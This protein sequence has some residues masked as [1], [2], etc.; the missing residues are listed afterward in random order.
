MLVA[1]PRSEA[2]VLTQG[3]WGLSGAQAPVTAV[4]RARKAARRVARLVTTEGGLVCLAA[5]AAYLTAAI[6]L[7]FVYRSLPGDAVSRMANGFYVLY[8]RDPHLAAIGFVWTPLTSIAGMVPLLFKSLW[9]ALATHD[10]AGSLV[11][12]LCMTGV[13]HQLRSSLLEWGVRRGPRLILTCLFALNPMIIFF[14]ANGMSEAVYMFALTAATRYL[15]RWL[16]NGEVRSIAYS[17]VALGLGYLA[18]NETLAAALLAALMVAIVSFVRSSGDRRRRAMEALTDVAILIG[19][20]VTA[21]VGWASASLVIT[22]QAFQQYQGNAV[23]V[24][25][26]GFTPGTVATRL[27]H[28]AV[29]L[30]F[31]APALP[32]VAVLALAL[33]WRRR[34]LQALV[35]VAILG[36]GLA[37]ILLSYFHGLLFPWLRYYILV[38]PLGVLLAGY[39]LSPSSRPALERGHSGAD[40]APSRDSARSKRRTKVIGVIG[41]TASF[42]ALAPSLPTSAAAM[43]D[44][45]IGAGETIQNLG[46]I[47]HAHLTPQDRHA[48]GHSAFVESIGRYISKMHLPDG[49]IVVDNEVGCVPEIITNIADPK[50]FVI[51]NDRDFQRVLADPLTFHAHYLID[52]EG[53]RNPDLV[54]AAAILSGAAAGKAILVHKFPQGGLCPE[55]RLYR[56]VGHPG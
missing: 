44:P 18:R 41:A 20:F 55:L 25:A 33:A 17:A 51:P 8:S 45:T 43:L 7:D 16:R 14:A 29:A 53:T 48:Q 23:L 12:V 3:E 50:V 10:M 46:F 54:S 22:G 34:E 4:S 36:G 6:V 31:L 21:M 19:P 11:T 32:V 39:V 35:P 9:P 2:E 26:A 13:V 37:F 47:F 24:K 38:I 5:A 28:E 15:L 30:V 56:V 1:D 49:S 52:A 27:S 40:R 42:V